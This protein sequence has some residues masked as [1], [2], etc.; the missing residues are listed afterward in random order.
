[1]SVIPD[2][3]AFDSE[4]EENVMGYSIPVDQYHFTEWY[5]FDHTTATPNFT[6]TK[7][8]NHT[9]PTMSFND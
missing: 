7:L 2:E 1:M 8:Y 3:P 4:S 5:R 9:E 6:G